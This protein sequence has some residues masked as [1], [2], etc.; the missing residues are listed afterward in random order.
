VFVVS[1]KVNRIKSLLFTNSTLLYFNTHK[2]I[3]DK[4][5]SSI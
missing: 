3:L 2:I 1:E 5:K 4:L